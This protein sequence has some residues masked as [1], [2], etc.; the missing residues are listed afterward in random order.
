MS[1]AT[2]IEFGAKHFKIKKKIL[3][4]GHVQLLISEVSGG[5]LDGKKTG[6]PTQAD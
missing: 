1:Y 3:G 2:K 4:A 6:Q 5:V